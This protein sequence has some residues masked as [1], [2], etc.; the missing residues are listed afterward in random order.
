[1]SFQRKP[2]K[3]K[4]SPVQLYEVSNWFAENDGVDYFEAR[5]LVIQK[6][7]ALILSG[8]HW[9]IDSGLCVVVT[10]MDSNEMIYW[11]ELFVDVC[12]CKAM[13]SITIELEEIE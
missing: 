10:L 1:M 4:Y 3:V 2:F 8:D 9:L 11:V 5:S 13:E 7:T 12:D 6:I